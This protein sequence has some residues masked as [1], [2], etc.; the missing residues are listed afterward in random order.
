MLSVVDLFSA[1]RSPAIAPTR[2]AAD[3]DPAPVPPTILGLPAPRALTVTLGIQPAPFA[4][5]DAE[6]ASVEDAVA[7][8]RAWPT[9]RHD[10]LSNRL[11]ALTGFSSHSELTL[12]RDGDR[13]HLHVVTTEDITVRVLGFLALGLPGIGR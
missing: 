3:D 9:L 2:G 5:V 1:R 13:V 8:E 6:L 4:D 10:L 7:W 11:V 12:T